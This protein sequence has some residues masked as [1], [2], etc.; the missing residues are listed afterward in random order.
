MFPMQLHLAKLT[1]NIPRLDRLYIQLVPRNDILNDPQKM[2]MVEPNDLWLERNQCYAQIMRQLFTS[3]PAGNYKH[4]KVFESGDAADADAWK[5][6]VE[7]VKR[8]GI[9]WHVVRDG[10]FEKDT[11]GA[12]VAKVED[13]YEDVEN[14]SAALVP[15]A[16][17]SLFGS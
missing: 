5:M 3:P 13:A 12:P 6:A 4:L 9:P 7:Y 11:Q 2:E 15:Q 17:S 8:A 14:V 10:V 16:V 1:D